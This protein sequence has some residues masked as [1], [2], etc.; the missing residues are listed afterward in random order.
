MSD[1]LLT[2]EQAAERLGTTARFPRRLIAERRI[3][4]VKIGRHVRIPESALNA[5]VD[6]N[7]VQALRRRRVR[8]GRA[9]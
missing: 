7:T 2:V 6:G 4:F 8:Y 5:Y 9:A 1:L 3:A